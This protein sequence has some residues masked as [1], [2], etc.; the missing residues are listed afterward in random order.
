MKKIIFSKSSI[1]RKDEYK[2]ITRIYEEDGKKFV[3]KCA[4]NAKAVEHVGRMVKISENSPYLMDGVKLVPC[5]SLAPGRV[6]FPYIEGV[7]FDKKIDEHVKQKQWDEV[8]K[9]V[10]LLKDIIFQVE[11]KAEFKSTP[12]FE[13]IFGKYPQLEGYEAAASVNLDM[14]AANIILADSIYV[15]DYEWNFEFLVPLKFILYRSIFLNGTLNV[16]PQEKREKL[17]QIAEITEEGFLL[18][19]DSSRKW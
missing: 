19:E 4:Q 18:D 15:L 8:W 3:E 12:E 10:S 9:D 14:V 6:V 7:R 5:T 1:E 13:R 2:I 17:M 11:G 16:I